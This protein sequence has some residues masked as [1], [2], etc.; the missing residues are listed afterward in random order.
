MLAFSQLSLSGKVAN[1]QKQI[2][3][4]VN[5]ILINNQNHSI[6][7]GTV[8]D[9]NGLFKF[10]NLKSSDY[11]LEFSFAGFQTLSKEIDLKSNLD[12]GIIKMT[13]G[14]T[15]IQGVTISAR[16]PMMQMKLDRTIFNVSQSDAVIGGNAV[17]ALKLTPGVRIKSDKIELIGKGAVKIM[18]NDQLVRLDG[19]DAFEYLKSIPAGNIDR[20]EIITNPPAKYSAEGSFG[21]IN[22][23]LKKG[24]SDHLYGILS[25]SGTQAQYFS[26]SENASVFYRK[27][28]LQING[29]LGFSRY[30]AATFFK[31]TVFYDNYTLKE[32]NDFLWNSKDKFGNLEVS[33]DL[34]KNTTIGINARYTKSDFHGTGTDESHFIHKN[35]IDSLLTTTSKEPIIS[36]LWMYNFYLDHKLDSLGS[37]ISLEASYIEKPSNRS[38][39]LKTIN[40]LTDQVQDLNSTSDNNSKLFQ[41]TFDV[42][43]KRKFANLNFGGQVQTSRIYNNSQYLG[44]FPGAQDN[45]FK[46]DEEVYSAYFSADKDFGD[47]WSLKLGLRAEYTYS[48]G[49]SVTLNQIT[50]RDYLEL[51][52]TVYLGYKANSD[53]NFSLSYGRRINRPMYS[54]LDPFRLYLS[55]YTYVEGNPFLRPSYNNNLELKYLY[56]GK[57]S[58][59]LSFGYT[60]N[61]YDQMDIISNDSPV[62]ATVALNYLKTYQYS[63]TEGLTL[64]PFS[65]WESDNQAQLFYSKSISDNPN[66]ERKM[67]GFSGYFSSD[68]TFYFNKSKTFR[69]NL[70]FNY[71]TPGV[72]HVEHDLS[73][74]SLN[75]GITGLLFSKSLT[76][77]L[78]ATDLFKTNGIRNNIVT[79]GILEKFR[80]YYDSR[81][82]KLA[83]TYTFGQSKNKRERSVINTNSNRL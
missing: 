16:K 75:L 17:D 33:Y 28:K 21:L 10:E 61:G 9:A 34:S 3:Q 20:I 55:T 6:V 44:A 15:E 48:K 70:S 64:N 82:V 31:E 39:D 43:L 59:A 47:S 81:G 14:E 76:I 74:G 8:S 13:K 36:H 57:W 49:N 37:K 58:S 30:E 41:T 11:R 1:S 65:W 46:Y 4:G 60:P 52:P 67:Q 27:N 78:Q 68:N 72:Y 63:L 69:G 24:K 25:S 80:G 83:A 42:I 12:L 66:T 77:T 5:I 51:F 2:L 7:G 50:K 71:Y 40:H 56:K 62:V 22:V 73:T 35:G 32:F 23:V 19:Q 38:S 26:T 53:N 54:Y 18:V 29:G 79:N 45:L